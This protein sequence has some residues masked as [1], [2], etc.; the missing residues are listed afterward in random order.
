M[1]AITGR[2][3]R[4]QITSLTGK[5]AQCGFRQ[6]MLYPRD[7]CELDYLSD[8]WFEVIGAFIE[9]GKKYGMRFWLYDEYNYPSGGC[10]GR[11][12]ERGEAFCVNY[13]KAEPKDGHYVPR[14]CVNEKYPNILNPE[15]VD[16]FISLT[17]EQ[18]K[19]RFG[20]YFGKEIAGI[21]TD[22]PSFYYGVW[23]KDELPF[24]KEMPEDYLSLAGK[25]FYSDYDL[26]YSGRGANEFIVN[27]YKLIAERMNK[28][29]VK[30]INAWCE[31]NGLYMTGHLMCDDR[32]TQ[33]VHA[34]GDLLMQLSSFSY[35]AVDDI[36]TNFKSESLLMTLSAIQ[37]AARSKD[38]AAAELFA[39]G[40]CDIPFA[41]MRAMIWYAALFGVNQYF[42]AIS[43]PAVR[44]N[45][46]R[47]FYYN[48]FSPYA[49]FAF[50][51][52]ELGREAEKAAKIA[53]LDYNPD[54]YIPFPWQEAAKGL[55]EESNID[56][57]WGALLKTL[58]KYQ[59]QYL[60][61]RDGKHSDKPVVE[62]KNNSFLLDGKV[63]P[64]ASDLAEAIKP[65]ECFLQ[66]D[67][68]LPED[69]LIRRYKNGE[70]VLL[71]LSEE[72]KKLYYKG[73]ELTLPQY[74]VCFAG[75]EDVKYRPVFELKVYKT[76]FDGNNITGAVFNAEGKFSFE[77][78]EDIEVIFALRSFPE[79]AEVLFDN[80]PLVG[81]DACDILPGNFN[82]L[83]RKSG[84]FTLTKGNHILTV[85]EER[86]IYKYLPDVLITGDFHRQGNI[87][88]AKRFE[89]TEV[90]RFG[91]CRF[92]F[93]AETPAGGGLAIRINGVD[94]PVGLYADG[95]A[96]GVLTAPP[97][98]YK[99]PENLSGKA[100][101]FIF[102]TASGFSPIFGDAALAEAGDGT[103]K[104]CEGYTPAFELPVREVTAEILR[105]PD[106]VNIEKL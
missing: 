84:K 23:E 21:F 39:L 53:R 93:E 67:G 31:E 47:R 32:P 66:K 45:A 106:G 8:E 96:L 49:P 51:Y 13:L 28:S 86:K 82:P 69:V 95:K 100:V 103:P 44:G 98:I 41:K 9:A 92:C 75:R 33:S 91:K 1:L 62:I 102:E 85:K 17:H 27:C 42:L 18:Y 101:S 14:I 81:K 104:W 36:F 4:G 50:G 15:A 99:L 59:I 79:N 83:Y 35:P 20:N 24:Y 74:G 71:N 97:Y 10:R 87:L 34:N 40:P 46:F 7:G 76:D 88:S 30:K 90:R 48:D 55:A 73:R 72:E 43:H 56:S 16:Y 54:V 80:I 52:E 2:P 3:T 77:A 78:K 6:L 22:E 70:T 68:C 65:G 12:M 26:Y 5:Y 58:R 63:Y 19:K 94:G 105:C 57:L 11:V 29:F 89:K 61:I 38:G 60:V 37:Y 64:S 25:D